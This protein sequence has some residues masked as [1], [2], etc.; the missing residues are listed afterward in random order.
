MVNGKG[1]SLAVTPSR[2]P[3]VID[4]RPGTTCRYGEGVMPL[5]IAPYEDTDGNY[6]QANRGVQRCSK[7]DSGCSSHNWLQNKESHY[8]VYIKKA[9]L[10]VRN[11]ST[12][13]SHATGSLLET[14]RE[15]LRHD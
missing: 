2:N 14:L 10:A 5:W 15:E 9:R 3:L 4:G 11:T 1:K 13:L 7:K 8:V 6:H 12:T